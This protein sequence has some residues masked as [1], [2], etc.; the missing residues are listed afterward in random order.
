MALSKSSLAS[1]IENNLSTTFNVVISPDMHKYA[2][3]MANAI[4]DE[5]TSNAKVLTNI[6]VSVSGT[7][8]GDTVTINSTGSTTSE[9][10]IS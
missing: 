9:G 1:R 4:V 3:A 10:T 5:I 2:L 6:P 8:T 7:V